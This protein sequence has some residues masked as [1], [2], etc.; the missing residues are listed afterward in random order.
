MNDIF[1]LKP[2]QGTENKVTCKY[3]DARKFEKKGE[4]KMSI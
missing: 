2:K 1:I 3:L 4:W